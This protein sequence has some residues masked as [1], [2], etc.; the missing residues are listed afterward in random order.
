M[1]QHRA[2]R[3]LQM[4]EFRQN[5]LSGMNKLL[6]NQRVDTIMY[7]QR[8]HAIDSSSRQQSLSISVSKMTALMNSA[9]F[10]GTRGC[11]SRFYSYSIDGLHFLYH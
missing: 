11:A 4:N 2:A 6:I 3:S 10:S 1:P 5:A 7:G 9:D 8:G